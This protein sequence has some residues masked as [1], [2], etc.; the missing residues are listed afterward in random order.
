MYRNGICS[1]YVD[2]I[3]ASVL[4]VHEAV[5]L[6]GNARQTERKPIKSDRQFG[7]MNLRIII[8]KEKKMSKIKK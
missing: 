2:H 3:V 8:A 4:S 7:Y 1:I 5:D 6:K